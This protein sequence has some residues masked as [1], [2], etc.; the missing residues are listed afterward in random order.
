MNTCQG[1]PRLHC[2]R[3]IRSR[4]GRL[5]EN[6]VQAWPSFGSAC[7]PYCVFFH[8]ENP[9]A[10]WVSNIYIHAL[11]PSVQYLSSSHTRLG[12]F[13]QKTTMA[14]QLDSDPAPRKRIAVA[15]RSTHPTTT[16]TIL[17]Q[18]LSSGLEPTST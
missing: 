5:W 14:D 11:G 3:R 9:F 4:I 16:T 6:L 7:S 1:S 2:R 15:V 8:F 18:A 17:L 13:T 10:L 12:C